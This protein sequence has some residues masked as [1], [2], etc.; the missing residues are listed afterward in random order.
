MRLLLL[1]QSQGY[2]S[3]RRRRTGSRALPRQTYT[4]AAAAATAVA[5]TATTPAGAAY[6]F[7]VKLGER[8]G[9]GP[10]ISIPIL[11][12]DFK[13]SLLS[14]QW[15]D[16]YT[17]GGGERERG[18]GGER[19][20]GESRRDSRLETRVSGMGGKKHIDKTPRKKQHSI[21]WYYII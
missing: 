10:I 11:G 21:T 20:R 5:A 15:T 13:R 14:T 9:G 8:E 6:L 12:Y 19:G 4:A 2:A 18:R 16:R 17:R 1:L 3:C 7:A